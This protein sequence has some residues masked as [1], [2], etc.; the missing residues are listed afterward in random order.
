M[1]E[2][3]DNCEKGEPC[4]KN[5]DYTHCDR[6]DTSYPSGSCCAWWKMKQPKGVPIYYDKNKVVGYEDRASSK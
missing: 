1:N 5:K 4:N 6:M 2:R 3:C